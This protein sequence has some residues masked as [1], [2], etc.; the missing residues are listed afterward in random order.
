MVGSND[1][2]D[3]NRGITVTTAGIGALTIPWTDFVRVDF[4]KQPD[5]SAFYYNTFDDPIGITG[6]VRIIDNQNVTGSIIF[7]LDEAW[8]IEML[9]GDD[10]EIQYKIPFRNIKKIIPK[11]YNYSI[12]ELK[13]GESLLLG[14]RRDV[15]EDNDGILVFKPG[16]EDPIYISWKRIDEII[17]N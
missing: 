8:E 16:N 9:E 12:I 15:S 5:L 6:T 11:N 4:E 17:L 13:N 10:D 3:E 2:N 1:V 14:D 7:D